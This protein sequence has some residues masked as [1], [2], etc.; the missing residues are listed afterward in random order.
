M[1]DARA[2]RNDAQVVEGGLG[3]AQQLVA[4]AVALV[5]ALDV[6]GESIGGAVAI[7]LD[8][9][10]DDQVGGHER[11]DAGR[12]AAQLGHGVAHGRQVHH[13]R[14]AGEVLEDDP[15]RHERDLHLGGAGSGSRARP[16]GRQ[17]GH[18]GLP[19]DP[20]AG[21]AEHVLEQDLDGHRHGGRGRAQASPRPVRAERR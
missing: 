10:V 3:P 9:V 11:V 8:R 2:G 1:D 21:V 15:G 19:H 6:E 18:V 20:A 4:L 16:P 14:D 13:R 17:G 12:V 7:D 5:L